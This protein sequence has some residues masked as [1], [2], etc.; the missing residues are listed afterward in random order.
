MLEGN[1]NH[2][3][4]HIYLNINLYKIKLDDKSVVSSSRYLNI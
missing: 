4:F 1:F 2:I 3:S